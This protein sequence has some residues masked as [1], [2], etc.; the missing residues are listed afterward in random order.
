MQELRNAKAS[1][2]NIKRRLKEINALDDSQSKSDALRDYV[3]RGISQ[4]GISKQPPAPVSNDADNAFMSGMN[5]LVSEWHQVSLQAREQAIFMTLSS[6]EML[7]DQHNT[8]PGADCRVLM[9]CI[10]ARSNFIS[11]GIPDLIDCIARVG[12]EKPQALSR[13][14]GSCMLSHQIVTDCKALLLPDMRCMRWKD[15]AALARAETIFFNSGAKGLRHASGSGNRGTFQIHGRQG[16]RLDPAVS[17]TNMRLPS[18]RTLQ[19]RRTQEMEEDK[20][21]R[22]VNTSQ[23]HPTVSGGLSP[24]ACQTFQ[25]KYCDGA[26]QIITVAYDKTL[27][28]GPSIFS[29][30]GTGE[31]DFGGMGNPAKPDLLDRLAF[32]E[33][34]KRF[35]TLDED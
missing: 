18:L 13:E 14:G 12:I 17:H 4:L 9:N 16:T 31:A 24:L 19:R 30:D 8:R 1:M 26:K 35:Y 5:R 15:T 29:T 7:C 6:H 10:Q 32:H 27:L 20:R 34:R 3:N 21:L 22:G 33:S 2:K 23:K 28:K 11:Y 25:E